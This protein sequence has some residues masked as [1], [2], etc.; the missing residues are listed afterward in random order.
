MSGCQESCRAAVYC[1]VCGRRKKPRGRDSMDN[2]LCDRECSGYGQE[3]LPGHLWPGE[4][5]EESEK[6]MTVADL[7]ARYPH[8][9][10]S[11][12][13]DYPFGPERLQSLEDP[14][15]RMAAA[16]FYL[17]AEARW[18]REEAARQARLGKERQSRP[19]AQSRE[20]VEHW[21]EDR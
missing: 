11:K 4:A 1:T 21:Q 15:L 20:H 6:D 2:G 8:V 17:A 16:S 12:A 14:E 7:L 13:Y 18:E 10:G 9:P 19:Q 3:P 5:L